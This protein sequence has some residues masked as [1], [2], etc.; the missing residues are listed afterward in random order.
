MGND[1]QRAVLSQYGQQQASSPSG[2][3]SAAAPPVA[4]WLQSELSLA[5]GQWQ[6]EQQLL[7]QQPQPLPRPAEGAESAA[8]HMDQYIGCAAGRAASADEQ[9]WTGRAHL[10]D[11][12]SGRTVEDCCPDIIVVQ[13]TNPGSLGLAVGRPSS[14]TTGRHGSSRL[15][16]SNTSG[17]H[18]NAQAQ[19]CSRTVQRKQ[20]GTGSGNASPLLQLAALPS[21]GGG[22]SPFC[23]Y[24]GC[25][26]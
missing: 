6:H 26:V 14:C 10:Q 17:R 25:E 1:V 12:H 24:V 21:S 16:G 8:V 22:A 13:A 4:P 9:S 11:T 7:L 18:P 23:E 3:S 5:A 19:E 20:H 15:G 2:G